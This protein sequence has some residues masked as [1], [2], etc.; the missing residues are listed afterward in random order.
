MLLSAANT[1][2]SKLFE[3][4]LE[5][6]PAVHTPIKQP[7]GGQILAPD[8]QT[9]NSL[10]RAVRCRGERGFAL[11]TGRWRALQRITASPNSIGD[12]VKAALVRTRI[13]HID[14]RISC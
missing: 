9:Y 13:E 7:A 4:L 11:L 10:L 2:D 6:D 5:T 8:N 14:L 3:P 1:Q 12:Y